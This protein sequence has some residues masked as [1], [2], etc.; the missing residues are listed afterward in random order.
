MYDTR[1]ICACVCVWHR[2]LTPVCVGGW[3]HCSLYAFQ[4]CLY[5]RYLY[6]PTA[7]SSGSELDTDIILK[8]K[9]IHRLYQRQRHHVAF[10]FSF[11]CSLETPHGSGHP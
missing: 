5:Y 4:K 3:Q 11:A 1:D 2:L 7:D 6:T 9:A 8:V 10:S